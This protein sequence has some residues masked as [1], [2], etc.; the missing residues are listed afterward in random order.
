LRDLKISK[1][2]YSKEPGSQGR[3]ASIAKALLILLSSL[4]KRKKIGPE[5]QFLQPHFS[6]WIINYLYG[7]T[8]EHGRAGYLKKATRAIKSFFIL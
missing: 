3:T 6:D 4:D 8:A 1:E 2:R 5:N 7:C